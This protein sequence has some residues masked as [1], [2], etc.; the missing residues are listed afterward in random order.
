MHVVSEKKL[1]A[2]WTKHPDA[3]APLRSWHRIAER[4]EWTRFQDVRASYAHASQ[5]GKF[6][7]FNIGGNKFRLIVVVHFNR[8]RIYVRDVLTHEQYDRDEWKKN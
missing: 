2:F 6:T 5:D 8:G 3:E 1:R 4:S 7:I